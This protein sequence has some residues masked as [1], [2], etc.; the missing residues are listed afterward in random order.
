MER[1]L[2]NLKNQK[3][4][5]GIGLKTV[6]IRTAP[7]FYIFPPISERLLLKKQ[8]AKMAS[9]MLSHVTKPR[10]NLITVSALPETKS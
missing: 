7:Q 8:Q 1:M 4:G 2:G 9:L 5:Y 6:V 10:L 3:E